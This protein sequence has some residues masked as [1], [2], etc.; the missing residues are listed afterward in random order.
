MKK[1]SCILVLLCML[2]AFFGCQNFEEKPSES[3]SATDSGAYENLA[4]RKIVLPKINGISKMPVMTLRALRMGAFTIIEGLGDR[5]YGYES[6]IVGKENITDEFMLT[7]SATGQ[8]ERLTYPEGFPNWLVGSGDAVVLQ[9]RYFYEWKSYATPLSSET[10]FDV[11]L[12]KVDGETGRVEIAD[13]VIQNSPFVNMCKINDTK[14]LSY[15]VTRA[16][17]EETE[18]AVIS[19]AFIYDVNG[20]KKEILR[21]KYENDVS[22]TNSRGIL[23]EKFAV[24]DGQIYGFGRQRISGE[25]QFF[26]YRY[27]ESGTLLQKEHLK[28]FEKII[29][30]EQPLELF[31]KDDYIVFRTYETLSNYIC[32]RTD[33]GTELIAKGAY[34]QVQYAVLPSFIIFM[35]SNVDKLSEEIKK[36]DFPLYVLR[37]SD[38]ELRQIRL[39]AL[40]NDPYFVEMHALS[41]GNAVITYCEDGKY[42]P[43][44]KKQFL[45]RCDEIN[46][47][48]S[49]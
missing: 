3:S 48:F 37:T 10:E 30:S 22:W 42:D 46:T 15:T 31:L 40:P 36:G 28:G 32:K 27:D 18:Y 43:M 38:G 41:N 29:G 9:N 25:Y 39:S 45:L 33:A 5:Y 17:S 49:E 19:S 13:E 20:N 16:P 44:Q 7:E 34:G 26:L 11:K 4:E 1:A 2:F 23:I 12:T 6:R 47:L 24:S 8:R 14:F 35:E 21:E